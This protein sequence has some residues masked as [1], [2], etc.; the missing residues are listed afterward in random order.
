MKPAVSI[1]VEGL[2]DGW[3]DDDDP[4]QEHIK[5]SPNC[6]YVRYVMEGNEQHPDFSDDDDSSVSKHKCTI[7]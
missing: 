3:G 2:E 4:W 7:V 5:W 6:F 1:A